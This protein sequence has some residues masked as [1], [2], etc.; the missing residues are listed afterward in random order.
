MAPLGNFLVG[1]LSLFL[2]FGVL[3]MLA[4]MA[5]LVRKSL[6]KKTVD[7]WTLGLILNAA[8]LAMLA[9][10]AALS[11]FGSANQSPLA[12]ALYVALEDFGA[13]AFIVAIR[14]ERGVRLPAAYSI[15]TLVAALATGAVS[16]VTRDFLMTYALHSTLLAALLGIAAVETLHLTGKVLSGRM[17]TVALALLMVDY[18]H[19]PI[20][21]ALGVRFAA[22]YPGL[23]SYVTMVLDICLGVAILLRATDGARLDLE[24][25]NAALAEAEHALREAAYTDA[26]CGIPNRTAFERVD[27]WPAYGCVAMIDLDGLKAI[28][29]KLGHAAGDAALEMAAHVLRRTCGDDGRIYRIGGDEFAGVWSRASDE[30]V[31]ASLGDAERE[32]AALLEIPV[33]VGISW[34]VATFGVERS[35]HE[36]L[37]EADVELYE[38][39]AAKRIS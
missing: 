30:S 8:A 15:L 16:F 22:S 27:Q 35:F 4:A 36:A 6:G 17:L 9:G 24:E 10:A 34:G 28:N 12:T 29:D 21:S 23:E 7:G 19:V 20:L 18:G 37:A 39:R 11:R 3:A 32:L 33:R 25:R 5:L 13:L 2:Q 38:K 31:R 14:E 1:Y 26:L